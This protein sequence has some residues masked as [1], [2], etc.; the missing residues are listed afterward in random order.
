MAFIPEVLNHFNIYN[1]GQRLIGDNGTVDL[2]EFT[3]IT[4]TVT[5]SGI[6][7]EIEEP[8]TGMFESMTMKLTWNVLSEEY[9]SLQNNGRALQ[10]TLRCSVQGTDQE[11]RFVDYQGLKIVVE[12]KAKSFTLGTIEQGKKMEA[13]TEIEITYIKVSSDTTTFVEL[14]KLNFRYVVNGEDLLAKI[15]SQV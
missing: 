14:D 11:G 1:S 2:P 9:F 5:G 10:L 13:E 6:L 4:D 15:R 3:A 7:G 12:G 8:V